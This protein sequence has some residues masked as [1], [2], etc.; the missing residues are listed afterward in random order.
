MTI[1]TGYVTVPH[2]TYDTFRNNIMGN[3]YEADGISGCQCVDIPK[4]LNYNIGYASPYYSTG[5]TGYA[6]GGWTVESARIFNAGE[7]TLVTS[8]ANVK[9]GDLIVLN[10]TQANPAGHVTF[11]DE[12]YDGSGYLWCVGQNQ[13]GEPLP[14]GGTVV[15]R[16]RLGMSD[17]LGGF[18]YNMW[19][20]TPP[21]ITTTSKFN[22]VLYAK[23]LRNKH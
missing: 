16:N 17:F 13:G 4:I 14:Q 7:C 11:A 21:V 8:L 12:N 1:Y 2:D 23:K 15:T 19:S 10:A 3:G 18:R 22:W 20:D 5:N 6:Y 9:R